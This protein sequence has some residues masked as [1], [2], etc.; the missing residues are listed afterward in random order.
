MHG[1]IGPG[2][3]VES[4]ANYGSIAK[5]CVGKV[6]YLCPLLRYGP[7]ECATSAE[8]LA[9]AHAMHTNAT[10]LAPL[11]YLF[12]TLGTMHILDEGPVALS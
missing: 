5:G 11:Q 9:A 8:S 6:P 7:I 1:N 4:A 10:R 2:S 12:V 3:L